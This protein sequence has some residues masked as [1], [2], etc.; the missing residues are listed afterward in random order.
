MVEMQLLYTVLLRTNGGEVVPLGGS[1][2]FFVGAYFD[3]R[4]GSGEGDEH[5]D[6]LASDSGEVEKACRG[7]LVAFSF[8]RLAAALCR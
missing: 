1:Y 5:S 3:R 4:S 7:T 8:L 2:V 6:E